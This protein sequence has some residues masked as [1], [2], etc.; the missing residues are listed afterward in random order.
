VVSSGSD[1]ATTPANMDDTKPD[2]GSDE[3][4][5]VLV[6]MEGDRF[7]VPLKVAQMSDLV[8][9]MIDPEELGA[10]CAPVATFLSNRSVTLTLQCR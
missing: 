2:G 6:S 5:V 7:E 10:S 8:K 9:T 4:K 3:T 1:R